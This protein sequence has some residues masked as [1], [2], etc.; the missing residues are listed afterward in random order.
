LFNADNNL[1]LVITFKLFVCRER[2]AEHIQFFSFTGKL[3]WITWITKISTNHPQTRMFKALDPIH[4]KNDVRIFCK[5]RM[6]IKRNHCVECQWHDK[7]W[8]LFRVLCRCLWNKNMHS[9]YLLNLEKLLGFNRWN[10][11]FRGLNGREQIVMDKTRVDRMTADKTQLSF[12]RNISNIFW[13]K[14]SKTRTE[15]NGVKV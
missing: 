3:T 12:A 2:V 8:W 15:H 9:F 1:F 13:L 6:N 4:L 11:N 10:K 5:K 14:I 7:L